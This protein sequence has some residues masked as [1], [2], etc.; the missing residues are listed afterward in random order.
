MKIPPEFTPLGVTVGCRFQDLGRNLE[1]NWNRGGVDFRIWVEIWSEIEIGGCRFLIWPTTW[2]EIEIGGVSISGFG[3]K[4]G[5][6]LKSGAR[7]F[8]LFDQKSSNRHQKNYK[9]S[10]REITQ[11]PDSAKESNTCHLILLKAGYLV[12]CTCHLLLSVSPK[13][14]ADDFCGT[15]SGIFWRL[16]CIR[17]WKKVGQAVKSE[18]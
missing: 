18:N 14:Y 7:T 2:S 12:H 3:S 9:V 15:D 13:K 11:Y 6:K 17:I 4:F 8:L 5:V 1:R 16:K 10:I